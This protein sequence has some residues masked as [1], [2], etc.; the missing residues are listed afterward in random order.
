M[1]PYCGVCNFVNVSNSLR[2]LPFCVF[3]SSGGGRA[4]LGAQTSPLYRGELSGAGRDL[5][6]LFIHIR[7]NGGNGSSSSVQQVIS[8]EIK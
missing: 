6:P 5:L 7:L 8:G 3:G 1:C 4:R 2:S